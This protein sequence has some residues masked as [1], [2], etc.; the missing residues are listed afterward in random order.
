MSEGQSKRKQKEIC[1]YSV[2]L[3]QPA[4]DETI[5]RNDELTEKWGPLFNNQDWLSPGYMSSYQ[6][7]I[8]SMLAGFSN[9]NV[10]LSTGIELQ[11]R[12]ADDQTDKTK[13]EQLMMIEE[14]SS[15]PLKHLAVLS[16]TSMSDDPTLTHE[17]TLSDD[18]SKN[19][20]ARHQ[21]IQSNNGKKR[22]I[23]DSMPCEDN[24]IDHST[25]YFH[26]FSPIIV[27]EDAIDEEVHS[28]LPGS[29]PFSLNLKLMNCRQNMC[30]LEF[31]EDQHVYK[32]LASP[33]S[34]T[35]ST[36]NL[37]ELVNCDAE[38]RS[39]TSAESK[40]EDLPDL[41]RDE[42]V[43]S[44]SRPPAI[45]TIQ[46]S[47]AADM[48][49]ER[50]PSIAES[51][52]LIFGMKSHELIAL[53]KDQAN[54]LPFPPGCIVLTNLQRHHDVMKYLSGEVV[55]TSFNL[56]A[57]KLFYHV[58]LN[59]G[60]I[61]WFGE[62]ELAY[63]PESPIY[64]S[65]TG[66]FDEKESL[67][68]G[69]ILLCST[70]PQQYNENIVALKQMNQA[71]LNEFRVF[72]KSKDVNSRCKQSIQMILQRLDTEVFVDH[73]ILELTGI[74]QTLSMV[75][76]ECAE[77]ATFARML[78]EKWH[79][80]IKNGPKFYYTVMISNASG[81]NGF[82][83]IEGIPSSHIKHRNRIPTT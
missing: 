63:A 22:C 67:S 40:T 15:K 23:V 74:K 32:S 51:S 53:R 59:D 28:D 78:M 81:I 42:P 35:E 34:S 71:L 58:L 25:R 56:V 72:V 17:N 24:P 13:R 61:S 68:Q 80:R 21:H 9:S 2:P 52:S 49:S 37:L 48:Q 79:S 57:R 45:S 38:K 60:K 46:Q 76:E 65:P 20:Q 73:S 36:R 43:L 19:P 1:S 44:S 27:D 70:Q 41:S 10:H 29:Y 54:I 11:Q 50:T 64:Y 31:G 33:S 8:K 66:L 7:G 30:D 6:R 75:S 77:C 12:A 3:P 16:P 83:V 26:Q 62:N 55:G 4:V 18:L 82:E 5:V 69:E 47:S 14:D 39:E